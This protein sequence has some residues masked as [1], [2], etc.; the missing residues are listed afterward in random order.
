MTILSA[1]DKA[2]AEGLVSS[3]LQAFVNN[4]D[5]ESAANLEKSMLAASEDEPPFCHELN[6][7]SECFRKT[8]LL[9]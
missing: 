3:H 2:K 6:L 5:V 7:Q 9:L 4:G 1:L 8:P